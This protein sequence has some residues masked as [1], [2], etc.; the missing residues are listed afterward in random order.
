LIGD[1]S[2]T[3]DDLEGNSLSVYAFIVR[4]DEPVGV[5]DVTRGADLSSTSVAHYQLQKLESLGLIEKDSFGRYTI[6]EKT[7]V[8][9]HVWVG[10]NLVPTLMFYSLFFMGVFTAEVSIILL[11]L[12]VKS[13]VIETS[14]WFLTCITALAMILFLKESIGLYR[15]LNPQTNK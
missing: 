8:G 14:F 11:S 10:K 1:K 4:S 12:A 9:G 3:A 6:K 5:R 13:V 7:S 15:K 2:V